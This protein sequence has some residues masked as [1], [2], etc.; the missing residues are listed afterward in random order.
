KSVV[1]T[2]EALDQAAADVAAMTFPR[3]GIN[4]VERLRRMQQLAGGH[5]AF[6]LGVRNGDHFAAPRFQGRS[7]FAVLS[8][9][10][11]S[12]SGDASSRSSASGHL[13]VISHSG[14][15]INVL[16]EDGRVQFL[17]TRSLGSLPDHPLINH[18]GRVEAG[19]TIDDATLAP[20]WQP[21][22][23]DSSQR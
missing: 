16:F 15:G 8:D 20:S 9:A 6:T 4:P 23:I 14:R 13:R 21:P 19:L 10:A 7:S 11:L 17:P 1:V 12:H 18:E 2:M 22:F 5:Y 3:R